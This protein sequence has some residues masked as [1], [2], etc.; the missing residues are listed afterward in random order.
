MV[1]EWLFFMPHLFLIHE[2]GYTETIL[3][4]L[5]NP[6]HALIP[7]FYKLCSA[8]P[9]WIPQINQDWES[10]Q[11]QLPQS[12]FLIYAKQSDSIPPSCDQKLSP[13][14]HFPAQHSICSP[15]LGLYYVGR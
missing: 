7:K 12:T 2:L 8:V 14:L 13:D 15:F 6:Q 3:I 5:K 11:L 10:A 1:Q 9:V 4:Q